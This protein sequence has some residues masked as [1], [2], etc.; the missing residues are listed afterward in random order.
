[1]RLLAAILVVQALGV[2]VGH[3]HHEHHAPRV[4]AECDASGVHLANHPDAPN[5]STHEAC[6]ACVLRS[7]SVLIARLTLSLDESPT[8][9]AAELVAQ[10][11]WPAPPS[12]ILGR[13]PPQLLA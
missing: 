13:A 8:A 2:S 5:L 4:L 6:P 10:V 1:L 3:T 12:R 9:S 11:G 7:Q